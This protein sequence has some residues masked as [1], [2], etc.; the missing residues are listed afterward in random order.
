MVDLPH[1]LAHE[2]LLG[3]EPHDQGTYADE[4]L[5][6][7]SDV[8]EEDQDVVD[9]ALVLVKHPVTVE[10]HGYNIAILVSV[11]V[12]VIPNVDDLEVLVLDVLPQL[13]KAVL[14]LVLLPLDE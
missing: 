12:V 5:G 9:L 13:H 1:D 4:G 11:D 8:S 3:E 2:H 6:E 7:A 10:V 14:Q